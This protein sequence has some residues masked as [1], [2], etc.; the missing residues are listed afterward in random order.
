MWAMET[1]ADDGIHARKA[2]RRARCKARGRKP[3]ITRKQ[4]GDTKAG[5]V[6]IPYHRAGG[7]M[8]FGRGVYK[9]AAAVSGKKAI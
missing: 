4:Q 9:T 5:E 8:A 2:R 1:F 6:T 7:S 3:E